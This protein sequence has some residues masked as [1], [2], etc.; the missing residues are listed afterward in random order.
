MK[1]LLFLLMTMTAFSSSAQP[2]AQRQYNE[3]K[4]LSEATQ[5][6]YA[7]PSSS[8]SA[9][10]YKSPSSSY[11]SGSSSARSSS[12]S[13]YNTGT[14]WQPRT[15]ED[16]AEA[17]RWR[18]QEAENNR[19][20]ADWQR[21]KAA[22]EAAIRQRKI[23]FARTEESKYIAGLR[24]RYSGTLS[25]PDRR[26]MDK[27][28]FFCY[29]IET[30]WQDYG[31][32]EAAYTV[33]CE[34]SAR[35]GY[36]KLLALAVTAETHPVAAS[37]C[38]SALLRR[39]PEQAPQIERN[40][41]TGLAYYFGARRQN[42]YP[43]ASMG[44][45]EAVIEDCTTSQRQKLLTLFKALAV[46]YPEIAVKTAGRSRAH[47]NP[48][49]LV[50]DYLETGTE[51]KAHWYM[52]VLQGEYSETGFPKFAASDKESW[53]A[54]ADRRLRKTAQWLMANSPRSVYDLSTEDWKGIA[55]SQAISAD[56]IAWAFRED[57]TDPT[58]ED[59]PRYWK[60]IPNLAKARKK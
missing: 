19:K 16:A 5:R 46:K 37:E 29:W 33:F 1:T 21:Q 28:A 10:A 4:R 36:E 60:R 23:D 32:A 13:N 26:E 3:Y 58:D 45:P 11:S 17:A 38:F 50:A 40:M 22:N 7:V 49:I 47:L 39:F 41:L 52:Q 24:E 51:S 42:L 34:D 54:Y 53:Q 12:A 48:F 20:Y 9:P 43:D 8:Y 59:Q 25:E 55:R 18:A 30:P 15:K 6:A 56:L 2:P 14:T 31:D 27:D 44:Y 35:A 57:N